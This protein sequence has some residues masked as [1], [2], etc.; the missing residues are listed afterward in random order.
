MLTITKILLRHHIGAAQF[1]EMGKW[2]FEM[3]LKKWC[4]FS[5]SA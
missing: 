4:N 2:V 5:C 1:W 3:N